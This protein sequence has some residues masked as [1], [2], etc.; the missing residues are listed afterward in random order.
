MQAE[1]CDA[2]PIFAPFEYLEKSSSL[3]DTGVPSQL[4]VRCGQARRYVDK[5]SFA[6]Q[7]IFASLYVPQNGQRSS[8]VPEWR[9]WQTR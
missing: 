1:I 7:T 9:N 8:L 6:G 2:T 5:A 4:A 3:D